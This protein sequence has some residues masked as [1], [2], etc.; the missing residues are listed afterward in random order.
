VLRRLACVVVAGVGALTPV[1]AAAQEEPPDTAPAAADGSPRQWLVPVPTGCPAPA[2]PDVV[3]LGTL[4]AKDF[5]TGRF[6]IDQVRAGVIQRY[7]YGDLV[8][9]RFG[10]DTEYLETGTQY[11]VGASLDPQNAV[12]TSKIRAEEPLFGGNDVIGAAETDIECP[13]LNDPVRTL[14]PNGSS[15]DSGVLSPLTDSKR[16]LLRALLLP[17]GVALAAVFALVAL[18]WLLTGIGW[19]VRSFTR[20]MSE[21]R[22]VRAA[23]RSGPRAHQP[24]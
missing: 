9:V 21:P 20:T 7:S 8:D 19:G 16:S 10:S 24:E 18:R 11:L 14:L 17:L 1:A 12:L 5:R 22:E 2:L 23:M 13:V 15:V 6:R 4:R 3:F